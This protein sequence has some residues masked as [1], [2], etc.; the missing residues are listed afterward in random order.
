MS[1]FLGNLFFLSLCM[2]V[3]CALVML[4]FRLFGK[5]FSSKGRY[6]VWILIV[7]RLA[8]PF[9][10][11]FL[12]PLVRLT[13]PERAVP[14]QEMTT[15]GTI[16]A[17]HP[18]TVPDESTQ[19]SSAQPKHLIPQTGHPETGSET[20]TGSPEASVPITDTEKETA[21]PDVS[22]PASAAAEPAEN[23]ERPA[24]PLSGTETGIGDTRLVKVLFYIWLAGA[25]AVL[26]LYLV[27]YL[28]FCGKLHGVPA[29]TEDGSSSVCA[30]A[31]R[32]AGIRNGRRIP[33]RYSRIVRT[34]MVLGVIFPRVYLPDCGEG[35]EAFRAAVRM[36]EVLQHEYLHIRRG[37]LLV[38]RLCLLARTLHW[39]NPL[40]SLA[41]AQCD[42]EAECSCD[43]AVLAGADGSI[44]ERYARAMLDIARGKL[45]SPGTEKAN[46]A[47]ILTTQYSP[48]VRTVQR[49]I[50]HI[51]DT[52]KKRN[53]VV[54]VILCLCF[55]LLA[56]SAFSY[57][58]AEAAP[59]SDGPVP[60]ELTYEEVPADIPVV[61]SAYV[62][63]TDADVPPD[64]TALMETWR[65][66]DRLVC[67]AHRAP[68]SGMWFTKIIDTE[69]GETVFAENGML[70]KTVLTFHGEPL[71]QLTEYPV[72]P[73]V[74]ILVTLRDEKPFL[75]DLTA[76]VRERM[77]E[78]ADSVLLRLW[79]SPSDGTEAQAAPYLAVRTRN[80]SFGEEKVTVQRLVFRDSGFCYTGSPET[81][82]LPL[83]FAAKAAPVPA[84]ILSDERIAYRPEDLSVVPRSQPESD[85]L[86]H[87]FSLHTPFGEDIPFGGHALPG[88]EPEIYC[89]IANGVPYYAVVLITDADAG[90]RR[91]ELH[92]FDEFLTEISYPM[93]ADVLKEHVSFFSGE[94][95]AYITVDGH[96]D[97]FPDPGAASG[98]LYCGAYETWEADG[99]T[100]TYR[101]RCQAGQTCLCGTLSVEYTWQKGTLVPTEV[102]YRAEDGFAV[103]TGASAEDEEVLPT[104]PSP[105]P[106]RTGI[107]IFRILSVLQ[108]ET[109]KEPPAPYNDFSH[110]AES[111]YVHAGGH[112]YLL[113][114]TE[115][116]CTASDGG[117]FADRENSVLRYTAEDGQL[118]TIFAAGDD[119]MFFD[120]F[121]EIDGQIYFAAF[122]S[123][124]Y[125]NRCTQDMGTLYCYDPETDSVS[126]VSGFE[127]LV[128]ADGILAGVRRYLDENGLRRAELFY[129]ASG[130]GGAV[131][132]PQ[133][134]FSFYD[135]GGNV[136]IDEDGCIR[137]LASEGTLP[138]GGIPAAPPVY[139]GSFRL[140]PKTGA[141]IR[142][143]F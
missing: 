64:A 69:S 108:E 29:D 88:T 113:P 123:Q 7:L 141:V 17:V 104:A 118:R 98:G 8:L 31:R 79:D 77:P 82:S 100:L 46:R 128:R 129:A 115:S 109:V 61:F 132:V 12:P 27:P 67:E 71:W 11:P 94:R 5:R 23:Y 49:R 75:C 97:T 134:G 84:E 117:Y 1:A 15:A 14:V 142:A 54:P 51:L 45:L 37:D 38:K 65:L 58:S 68:L 52:G 6:L 9:R 83:G 34:P 66:S 26:L 96:T 133:N 124:P 139:D 125:Q 80:G 87:G 33:V 63:E 111:W 89:P 16:S 21:V 40:V 99:N 92:L 138:A 137:F 28:L 53:G 22:V 48:K 44:R 59:V 32:A 140:D 116:A 25:S 13:L 107:P 135:F 136:T 95:N 81:R 103:E 57:G 70:L 4:F 114:G 41:A 24:Q 55:C 131:P 47:E 3:L 85:G 126:A 122:G 60:A 127:T 105:Y 90:V 102:R 39:F 10:T 30:E 91:T 120:M 42:A 130:T 110:T 36:R 74:N 20:E 121:T 73:S 101:T 93:P 18:E 78:N 62:P 43:E 35:A 143:P 86:L 2:S 56:G 106:D 76:A 19:R 50:E 112:D 119:V 72:D